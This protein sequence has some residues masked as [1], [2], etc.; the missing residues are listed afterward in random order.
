MSP[1]GHLS[2]SY[3]AGG[4]FKK[5][6]MPAILIGGILPDIDFIFLPFPFFNHIHRLATHNLFFI[7]LAAILIGWGFGDNKRWYVM[8]G[9]LLGGLLHLL[10]DACMD[11]NPTNGIGV[12]FLW[13]FDAT[14]YSPFN[15]LRPVKTT[16]G[17]N[18]PINMIKISFYGILYE[19][20][21][22]GLALFLFM[23]KRRHGLKKA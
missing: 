22:C 21:V 18:D 17:W 3:L 16:T 20:P 2:I 11:S 9:L 4:V 19:I 8:T 10:I 5:A 13:P 1:I 7:F 23:T 6:C 15:L 14:C 12:P